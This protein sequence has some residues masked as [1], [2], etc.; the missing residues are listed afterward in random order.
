MN[1]HGRE[2]LI[3]AVTGILAVAVPVI[4]ARHLSA[5]IAALG[6]KLSEL[7]GEPSSIAGV[8]AGLS[9]TVRLT[10]VEIGDVLRVE[11][12]EAS[13][14]LDSLLSGDFGVDEVRLER[15]R[16]RAYVDGAGE[17]NLARIFRRVAARRAKR[18]GRGGS[19]GRKLRRIVVTEGD[20]VLDVVG[21]GRFEAR[22]V[23]LH[24]QKGGVRVVTGEVRG[25]VV[26]GPLAV[27]ATFA[28]GGG[29]LMLP[30]ARLRRFLAVGGTVDARP[31]GT[32]G[33]PLEI[34][35]AALGW[36]VWGDG[37]LGLRGDVDDDGV[38]RALTVTA[39]PR[40]RGVHIHGDD[41]PLAFLEPLAPRGFVLDGAR[42]GG[43]LTVISLTRRC[44]APSG[45]WSATVDGALSGL[46][47]DHRAIA[48]DPVPVDGAIA[49]DVAV[50]RDVVT[51]RSLH[52]ARGTLAI[53][54]SGRVRRGGPAGLVA[55]EIDLRL[56]ETACL[57][58]VA[59]IPAAVR[60]P[61]G[62][63]AMEG[64]ISGSLRLAFDLDAPPGDAI[65]L[66]VDV[67]N[68]CSVLAD[69]PEADVRALAAVADHHFPDGST[70]PVGP[71]VGD[72]VAM[73]ALPA[74]VDGAFV[75][76]EDARFHDHDGFDLEQIARSL[77]VDL[78]EGR[79]ARGGSTISQQLVKNAFL[80]HRRTLDRKLQEAIL[81]WRLEAVLTKRQI[82]E[83]YLNV[84][85][86]GP[87]IHGIGAAA[88][89]W[90]GKSATTLDVKEAAFLAA[91]TP[92]PK[93]MSRRV[94]A[95][96]G[97]DAQSTERVE[98]VLRHMNR[99]GLISDD[100]RAAAKRATL[101]FRRDA[102]TP[103]PR[104]AAR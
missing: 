81:T 53:D 32:T 59:A 67:G 88:R 60:G 45:C 50:E 69:P 2:P 18:P 36:N 96:G 11:A 52:L 26:A 66:A 40:S 6:P 41:V 12:V 43:T 65:E 102:L 49:I 1:R 38:P 85:E 51:V 19:G 91:M 56:A 22:G 98:T 99:A 63:L 16:L 24:P 75:A 92:E 71:G 64:R 95:A 17:S 55:G 46:I 68:G 57:D 48:D 83:R 79:F 15:P 103:A 90:F 23:E 21:L 61:L 74:H 93:S 44:H 35:G 13:V 84:V 5:R 80:D 25:A 78:R 87:R 70:A 77:E 82:L 42:A 33:A 104:T 27:G 89:H 86:L 7:T 29:D 94:I 4:A 34:R 58:A 97:L 14:A 76:A 100:Q 62:A 37:L 39:L 47:V 31:D 20:L 73:I 9:G 10:G 54:G 101:D 72:W 30:D 3:L 8:E 28:R